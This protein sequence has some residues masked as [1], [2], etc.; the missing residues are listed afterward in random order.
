MYRSIDPN[1]PLDYVDPDNCNNDNNCMVIDTLNNQLT[2]SF[3]DSTT[4][5]L[6]YSYVITTFDYNNL[7]RNS[8]IETSYTESAD[9]ILNINASYL[10]AAPQY[11]YISLQY[12]YQYY[13]LIV[14]YQSQL[15][16]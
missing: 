11:S 14:V 10:K 16:P 1:L 3:T 15:L 4:T 5:G 13:I 7:Y 8:T 2:V 6:G 9:Y 12:G